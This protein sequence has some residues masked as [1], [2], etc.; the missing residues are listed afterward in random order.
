MGAPFPYGEFRQTARYGLHC[1]TLYFAAIRQLLREITCL[2]VR[3][4]ALYGKK[5]LLSIDL[6][7]KNAI[8]SS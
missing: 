1:T 8:N 2:G 4:G 5:C 7:L 3:R 6:D